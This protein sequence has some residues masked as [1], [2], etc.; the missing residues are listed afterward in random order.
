MVAAPPFVAIYP[1]RAV[2]LSGHLCAAG[3]GFQP[4]FTTFYIDVGCLPQAR[5]FLDFCFPLFCGVALPANARAVPPTSNI[6]I[7]RGIVWN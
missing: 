3:G 6:A 5:D 4:D 7:V 1:R 2:P